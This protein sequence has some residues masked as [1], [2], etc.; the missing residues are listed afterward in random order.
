MANRT[1]YGYGFPETLNINDYTLDHVVRQGMG[2]NVALYFGDDR[3]TYLELQERI[4]RF[5]NALRKLNIQ[6]GTHLLFRSHNCPEYWIG[7]LGAMKIGAVPVI[8]NTLFRSRELEAIIN[9]NQCVAVVTERDYL[10]P[11]N[12]VQPRCPSL[13]HVILVG[14]DAEK[15][16]LNFT[17]LLNSG[18]PELAAARL[19][20]RELGF[21]INTSG[22]TG[23]PKG[24]MHAHTWCWCWG[25]PFT[26]QMVRTGPESIVYQ[27]QEISFSYP[28]GTLFFYPLM[29][30]AASVLTPGRPRNEEDNFAIIQKYRVTHFYTVPTHYRILLALE[31]VESKF[32]LSSLTYCLS[33]GEPITV[34]HFNAWRRRFEV[35]I[36]DV[37]GQTEL[38]A[39]VGNLRG[40]PIKPGSMGKTIEPHIVTILDDN[41]NEAPPN[42]AGHLVVKEDDPGVCLGYKNM[43]ESWRSVLKNGYYY[44]RDYAS[45]DED[46]YYWY[47]SRSDDIIVSR[48]YLVSPKEVED[49]LAEHEAVFEPAVVAS[50]DPTIGQKVKAFITLK[51]GYEAS[52]QLARQI[53]DYVKGRI[54]PYKAPREISFRSELP[55]TPTGKIQRKAL[56]DEELATS[57]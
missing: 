41:G 15:G 4:N 1:K 5:G 9:S 38:H 37:I 50:P 11:L 13:K 51:P 33:A 26:E 17:D 31:N 20:W 30:G 43:E 44:T 56:R 54:A 32:D 42:K 35:D 7:V 21:I 18:G 55:K 49:A 19:H 6:R 12:Q 3:V 27:P 25:K 57:R 23:E 14:D 29:Y 10:G 34:E 22:T 48:G 40:L 52:D 36:C 46:G 45:R 8:S 39:F 28:F 53:I 47:V 2:K 24:V 16:E